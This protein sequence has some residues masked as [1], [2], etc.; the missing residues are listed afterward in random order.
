MIAGVQETT[1]PFHAQNLH[2]LNNPNEFLTITVFWRLLS[3]NIKANAYIDKRSLL[4]IYAE[5]VGVFWWTNHALFS[6]VFRWNVL[7]SDANQVSRFDR[8]YLSKTMVS[9][10]YPIFSQKMF[11]L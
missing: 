9:G 10:Y 5:L 11:V 8:S 3:Q 6:I 1:L 4:I 7:V 2:C